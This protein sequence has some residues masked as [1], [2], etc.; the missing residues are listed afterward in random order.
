MKY[1]IIYLDDILIYLKTEEEHNIHLRTVLQRLR[2]HQL[3]A[4]RSKCTFFT[5]TVEYLG[6]VISGNGI[7]P[8]PALVKVIQNFPPP[9]TLKQIQSFLGL[10]NYYYQ[11]INNY[12]SIA[13]PLTDAL[14]NASNSRPII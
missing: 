1:V 10:M 13:R 8:N 9:Q 4:K 3:Y 7:Q 2:D 11:Y 12:S 6:H 5:N 14:Q